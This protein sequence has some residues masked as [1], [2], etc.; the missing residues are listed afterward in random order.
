[1]NSIVSPRHSAYHGPDTLAHFNNFSLVGF[2]NEFRLRAPELW[3]LFTTIAQTELHSLGGEED[4][5]VVSLCTLLKDRSKRV[6]GLELLISFMLIARATRREVD[7]WVCIQVLQN[8]NKLPTGHNSS[9]S[10]W[11]VFPIPQLVGTFS[12]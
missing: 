1:M 3:K 5:T 9:Q 6:L 12:S 10:S 7:H 4:T 11:G 2:M 8:G